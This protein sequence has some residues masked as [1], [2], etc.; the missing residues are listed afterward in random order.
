MAITVDKFV[1]VW[2]NGDN[3]TPERKIEIIKQMKIRTMKMAK[4]IGLNVT[5]ISTKSGMLYNSSE[6]ISFEMRGKDDLH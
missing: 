2:Q 4:V 1:V 6:S 5:L 3:D